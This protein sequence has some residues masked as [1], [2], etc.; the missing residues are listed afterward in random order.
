MFALSVVCPSVHPSV[1]LRAYAFL[2]LYVSFAVDN[3]CWHLSV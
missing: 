2:H 3:P 1:C